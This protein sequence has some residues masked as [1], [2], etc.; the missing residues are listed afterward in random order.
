MRGYFL[1]QEWLKDN[2]ITKAHPNT[3][4]SSQKLENLELIA[5]AIGSTTGWKMSFPGASVGLILF[6]ITQRF[7][8]FQATGLI[9]ESS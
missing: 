5:Q 8:F 6:Q 1:E 9:S 3:R 7:C 4:G 2:C